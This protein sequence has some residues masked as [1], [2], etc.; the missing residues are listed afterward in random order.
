[1][2]TNP[3]TATPTTRSA[4]AER[5][6]LHRERKR[7]GLRCLTVELRETE[8]DTLIRRGMLKADARNDPG[9]ICKAL[10]AHL[11]ST[12]DEMP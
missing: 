6:H 10:Y 3:P 1:M 12:L 8:I 9:A 11:E 4:A 5:M 7:Q 2:T